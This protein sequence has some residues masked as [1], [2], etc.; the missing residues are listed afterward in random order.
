MANPIT[1][2]IVGRRIVAVRLMTPAELAHEG[3][4]QDARA[5][6]MVLNDGSVLYASRDYEGNGPGALFGTSAG[7]SFYV[8]APG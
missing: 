2:G 6:A 4:P 8:T 1:N 5:P 3:W 7:S